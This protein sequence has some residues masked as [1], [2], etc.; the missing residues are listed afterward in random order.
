MYTYIYIYI[1][2]CLLNRIR[3]VDAKNRRLF[4]SFTLC[5]FR[6]SLAR[7]NP[8]LFCRPAPAIVTDAIRL[9]CS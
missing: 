3:D 6:L 2:T 7:Q 1:Y 8:V 5:L 9:L 4:L